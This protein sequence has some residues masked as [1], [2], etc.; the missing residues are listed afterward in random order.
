MVI[1]SAAVVTKARTLIARQYLEISRLQVEGLLSAFAKLV[2]GTGGRTGSDSSHKSDH[3]FV[4]TEAVRF[5]YQPMESG[6]YLVLMTTKNSNMIENLETLR[7]LSRLLQEICHK[8]PASSSTQAA[9]TNQDTVLQNAFDIV[10]AFDEAISFGYREPVTVAQIN[11][12][13][14]M[15]SHEERLHQMIQQS[16]ENEAKETARRKQ[17]ELAELRKK[18]QREEKMA[19]GYSAS[20]AGGS[21]PVSGGGFG[22]SSAGAGAAFETSMDGS[23]TVERFDRQRRQEDL[24]AR[25]AALVAAA[26]TRGPTEPV[27]SWNP[28]MNA[29][30]VDYSVTTATAAAPKR[31]MA[32]GGSGR[33]RLE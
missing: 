22:S 1:I 2:D 3:T 4:E 12:Y 32:L 28:A 24:L 21:S 26:A 29:E 25:Q 31:G 5:V 16:K 8:N 23:D 15:E 13:V 10:F 7:L 20:A 18:Q 6:L 19:A 27:T 11:Q 30:A 14:E 9:I 17:M 33:R